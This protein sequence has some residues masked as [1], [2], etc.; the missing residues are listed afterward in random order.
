[1]HR[2]VARVG[3]RAVRPRG[4]SPARCDGYAGANSATAGRTN[5]PR[6]PAR[7]SSGA[8]FEAPRASRPRV[9]FR[10]PRCGDFCPGPYFGF[11]QPLCMGS[12]SHLEPL[13]AGNGSPPLLAL[14]RY[15]S[16][17]TS[18]IS[19]RQHAGLPSRRRPS[20]RWVLV[21][22]APS[23]A[24]TAPIVARA[25]PAGISAG[26]RSGLVVNRFWRGIGSARSDL[27]RTKH[28]PTHPP[29]PTS[30]PRRRESSTLR[31]PPS[32]LMAWLWPA[33]S[34]SGPSGTAT[35]HESSAAGPA[36]QGRD[37]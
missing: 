3:A 5:R 4:D 8:L 10:H 27:G 17:R 35:T 26:H 13:K 33:T 24:R 37:Q 7:A 34:N 2:Y 23:Q 15:R 32:F 36:Q 21:P 12:R 1:M 6:R 28:A 22:N 31:K 25:D 19:P 29:P 30:F 11:P 9:A 20:P 14:C 16:A 18:W